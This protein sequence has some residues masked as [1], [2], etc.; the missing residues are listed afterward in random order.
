MRIILGVGGGAIAGGFAAI[1]V[2]P[3]LW[4]ITAM[5]GIFSVVG[6]IIPEAGI[7][8][9][10]GVILG[11]I[12]NIWFGPEVGTPWWPLLISIGACVGGV[13]WVLKFKHPKATVLQSSAKTG[14]EED[15][16]NRRKNL[17][18]ILVLGP[19]IGAIVGILLCG[20]GFIASFFFY[21]CV[22]FG[23]IASLA[24]LCGYVVAISMKRR[25]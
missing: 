2:L 6:G 18:T 7:Y 8:A 10:I 1:A 14:L 20:L 12:G 23:V 25:G 22:L 15:Y 24:L 16:S 3:C 5:I 4:F 11:F 19:C 13:Q 17:K 9:A 21:A